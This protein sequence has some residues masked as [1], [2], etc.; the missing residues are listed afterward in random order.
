MASELGMLDIG[1]SEFLVIGVVALVVIGPRELPVAMRT[2]G[3]YVARAR[4]MARDFRDGLDD[5]ADQAELKDIE[6]KISGGLN[7]DDWLDED[8]AR[9]RVDDD[10]TKRIAADDD[11]EAD[12]DEA[13]AEFRDEPQSLAA[14]AAEAETTA[15]VDVLA[16]AEKAAAA[17]ADRTLAPSKS[18]GPQ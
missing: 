9:K 14:N 12:L 4:A 2:A 17:E 13:E 6:N 10:E 15:E 1:W 16:E 8:E 5:I 11:A 18:S 3:R 7:P